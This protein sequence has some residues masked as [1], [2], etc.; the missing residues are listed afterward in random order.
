MMLEEIR[1]RPDSAQVVAHIRELDLELEQVFGALAA[2]GGPSRRQ[3]KDQISS[4]LLHSDE[5][6]DSLLPNLL[7]EQMKKES[8]A[9]LSV[10]PHTSPPGL[11]GKSFLRILAPPS[12][13]R[14]N[15]GENKGVRNQSYNGS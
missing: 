12:N 8:E 6:L 1:K 2:L 10:I 3:H 9:S 14:E 15:K 4:M 5:K 11:S 7:Q 13:C